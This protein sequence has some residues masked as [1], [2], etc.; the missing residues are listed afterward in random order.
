MSIVRHHQNGAYNYTDLNRVEA[1]VKE[2]NDI[3]V[4]AKYM[5]TL[6]TKLD[7]THSDIFTQTDAERYLSNINAVRNALAVK[8]TTP[9]TPTTMN[10]LTYSTAND[11]EKILVDINDLVVGLRN[12][13]VY[14]GVSNSGQRRLWQNRFRHFY[15]DIEPVGENQLMTE[16]GQGLTTELG[17]ELDYES[18]PYTMLSWIQATSTQWINT[19]IVPSSTIKVETKMSSITGGSSISGSEYSGSYRYKWGINGGN[20]YYRLCG[21]QL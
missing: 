5:T 6:T 17:E 13:F 18:V 15:S 8:P 11:I 3:L 4:T 19:G 1:K 20:P 14:S 2:L 16:S 21:Q 9:Q 7:W 12:W 10:R